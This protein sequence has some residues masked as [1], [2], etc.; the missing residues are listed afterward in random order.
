MAYKA[1]GLI[2][3]SGMLGAVMASDAAM[4]A[5]YVE[6]LGNVRIRGGLTTVQLLGDVAAVQAAVEA[7]VKSVKDSNCFIASHVIANLD[8]QV[9]QMLMNKYQKVER[10]GSKQI[11]KPAEEVTQTHDQEPHTIKTETIEVLEIESI[12]SPEEKIREILEQESEDSPNITELEKMKVVKLRSLA[13][14]RN[15][16]TLTKRE[17]K[18][19]NKEALIH[20]LIDKGVKDE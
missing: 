2:E 20:A 11:N 4:K 19:A 13:Y 3:V 14:Q 5:A 6:L 9:E 18:F 7:G 17:I 1:L 16:D 15:I 10:S 8:E 12:E